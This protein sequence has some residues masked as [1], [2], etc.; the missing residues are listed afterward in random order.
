MI[1]NPKTQLTKI[2]SFK[3]VKT[4]FAKVDYKLR[5]WS[6]FSLLTSLFVYLLT[7]TSAAQCLTSGLNEEEQ[8]AMTK[9]LFSDGLF[10]ASSESSKC[11]L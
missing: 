3:F 8:L 1:H 2:C 4:T 10:P 11:F 5:F 7:G 9:G 6:I